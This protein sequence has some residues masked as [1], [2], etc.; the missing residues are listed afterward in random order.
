MAGYCFS[1]EESSL[2]SLFQ[3]KKKL[4]YPLHLI[5]FL[6]SPLPLES[7]SPPLFCFSSVS[8]LQCILPSASLN[9]SNSLTSRL[10]HGADSPGMAVSGRARSEWM[11]A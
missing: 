3:K 7:L 5:A 1:T 9:H 8:V 11:L 2:F 6:S 10:D 4:F